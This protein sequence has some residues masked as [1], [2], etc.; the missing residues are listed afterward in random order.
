[1]ES[2]QDVADAGAPAHADM[3]E[4]LT[5]AHAAAKVNTEVTMAGVELGMVGALKGKL[6]IAMAREIEGDIARAARKAA[7]LHIMQYEVCQG[8]GI[9]STPLSKVG[10]VAVP[11]S[12]GR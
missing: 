3:D 1:M 10:G 9:D 4:H 8:H 2:F 5:S 11:L 12:G 6:M 7:E